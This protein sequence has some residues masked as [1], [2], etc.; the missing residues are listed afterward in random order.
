MGLF[1][2][3]SKPEM[4]S[5]TTYGMPKLKLGKAARVARRGGN[6]IV[7]TTSAAKPGRV[8][9]ARGGSR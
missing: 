4:S 1:G 5:K 9:R 6:A 8:A 3:G 7:A 2:A